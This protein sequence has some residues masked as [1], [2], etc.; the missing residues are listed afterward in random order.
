MRC[1]GGVGGRLPGLAL[2]VSLG[3]TQLLDDVFCQPFFDFSMPV[4]GLRYQSCLPPC[5]TKTPPPPAIVRIKSTRFMTQ[6]V[7]LP[8][9][10]LVQRHWSGL[11]TSLGDAP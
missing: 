5:R 3:V 10:R 8:C 4:R 9:G 1:S 11:D 2:G 6:P 7:R